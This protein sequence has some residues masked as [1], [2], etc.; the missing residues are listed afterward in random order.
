MSRDDP[1]KCHD[2]SRLDRLLSVVWETE[3]ETTFEIDESQVK[4][5]LQALLMVVKSKEI[6][7][8]HESTNSV[9]VP[10][11]GT[12]GPH[13]LSVGSDCQ[14]HEV[15]RSYPQPRWRKEFSKMRLRAK[16]SFIVAVLLDVAFAGIKRN[17]RT[18]ILASIILG[19]TGIAVAG[20]EGPNYSEN[21]SA[22][23]GSPPIVPVAP[24]ESEIGLPALDRGPSGGAPTPRGASEVYAESLLC[25]SRLWLDTLPSGPNR[26]R[27]WASVDQCREVPEYWRPWLVQWSY[28]STDSRYFVRGQI[29]Y[30]L[31]GLWATPNDFTVP[32]EV[33]ASTV[34]LSRSYAIAYMSPDRADSIRSQEPAGAASLGAVS[35]S[36]SWLSAPLE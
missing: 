13:G 28:S 30:P 10:R 4:E 25:R 17:L 7:S 6:A 5:R 16:A 20:V 27:I 18:A 1:N 34:H 36:T 2:F 12:S 19:T 29:G 31:G 32:Q 9:R 35:R 22:L 14:M 24:Y 26:F 15:G 8:A 3:G 21:P 23:P 33:A 11:M